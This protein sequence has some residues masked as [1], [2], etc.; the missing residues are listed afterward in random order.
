MSSS[1]L[2]W[3]EENKIYLLNR[4]LISFLKTFFQLGQV[5]MTLHYHYVSSKGWGV[6]S[7]NPNYS[8]QDYIEGHWGQLETWLTIPTE[9]LK[10]VDPLEEWQ[11]SPEVQYWI[12]KWKE[13]LSGS[14]QW[15]LLR[16]LQMESSTLDSSLHKTISLQKKRFKS[17]HTSRSQI[18][19]GTFSWSQH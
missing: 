5:R 12:S 10:K 7:I 19:K 4:S 17:A 13:N 8:L 15:Q 6:R 11:T 14:S 1:T 2:S 18:F 16:R 9:V 3:T